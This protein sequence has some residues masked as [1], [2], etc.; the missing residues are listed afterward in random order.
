MDFAIRLEGNEPGEE[1]STFLEE[2]VDDLH[3]G[4]EYFFSVEIRF[5][6]SGTLMKTKEV[7][8][9]MPSPELA[10]WYE[11]GNGR[12][13]ECRPHSEITRGINGRYIGVSLAEDVGCYGNELKVSIQVLGG[14][15]VAIP[16]AVRPDPNL[17]ELYKAAEKARALEEAKAK[18][19]MEYEKSK[20]D[21]DRVKDSY[22]KEVKKL[23][24][25]KNLFSNAEKNAQE[26]P[27]VVAR[28]EDRRRELALLEDELCTLESDEKKEGK[29]EESEKLDDGNENKETEEFDPE[30][31]DAK[32]QEVEAAKSALLVEENTLELMGRKTDVEE[33]ITM[34]L[35]L[36]AQFGDNGDENDQEDN[37]EI[38]NAKLAV[39][40]AKEEMKK[41]IENLA[42]IVTTLSKQVEEKTAFY[43]NMEEQYNVAQEAAAK[44]ESSLQL[45]FTI[46]S[47]EES[48][49]RFYLIAPEST[50]YK[51]DMTQSAILAYEKECK[52][53]PRMRR[54]RLTAT[55]TWSTTSGDEGSK[56]FKVF[57]HAQ[58]LNG[59]ILLP[60]PE[61]SGVGL[62]DMLQCARGKFVKRGIVQ[63][64]RLR[65][66]VVSEARLEMLQAR[67]VR[68]V[69]KN[70][71]AKLKEK[72]LKK[73]KNSGKKASTK[74]H[75]SAMKLQSLAR[76]KQTRQ[77][78]FH[79]RRR[80][81]A[82][83]FDDRIYPENKSDAAIKIQALQRSI[84]A[85]K[86]VKKLRR[87]EEHYEKLRAA[88]EAS[89]KRA[90]H[91]RK[92]LAGMMADK[93]ESGED[94]ESHH[95]DIN[96]KF[97]AD[98]ALDHLGVRRKKKHSGDGDEISPGVVICLWEGCVAAIA[99]T[100]Q[101]ADIAKELRDG[102]S[103]KNKD[104]EEEDNQKEEKNHVEKELGIAGFLKE[105]T[106][107]A[108]FDRRQKAE[109]LELI[110]ALL[111]MPLEE[112][113]E[114]ISFLSAEGDDFSTKRGRTTTNGGA[115]SP[116]LSITNGSRAGTRNGWSS[117]NPN[118]A[119]SRR[120]RITSSRALSRRSRIAS[121]HR[122]V[123]RR[124]RAL[125]SRALSSR[126]LSRRAA[127]SRSISRA[128]SSRATSDLDVALRRA[129]RKWN[130]FVNDGYGI[131]IDL[132]NDSKNDEGGEWNQK[133][134]CLLAGAEL[135]QLTEYI[136][137]SFLPGGVELGPG[138]R[139]ELA[140][141]LL[142]LCTQ[143]EK[144]AL[145]FVAW[146]E[147]LE[148]IV[149]DVIEFRKKAG[150]NGGNEDNLDDFFT[151]V[152]EAE[153]EDLGNLLEKFKF[154]DE[155][156]GEIK[157]N[158]A[159][160]NMQ[161]TKRFLRKHGGKNALQAIGWETRT[162]SRG[163]SRPATNREKQDFIDHLVLE[164]G[165]G[166]TTMMTPVPD[167]GMNDYVDSSWGPVKAAKCSTLR[168]RYSHRA[169]LKGTLKRLNKPVP[170]AMLNDPKYKTEFTPP[171]LMEMEDRSLP[172][173]G[174][175]PT[176]RFKNRIG[177]GKKKNR[178]GRS[179]SNRSEMSID[180]KVSNIS[181]RR[182]RPPSKVPKRFGIQAKW[183]I[184]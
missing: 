28:L 44:D 154:D 87:T 58:L 143:S 47:E 131:F 144:K 126:A 163:E 97:D 139:L 36:I 56:D 52:M 1:G 95:V 150:V 76:G 54:Q 41:E 72:L 178:R 108:R 67:V 17:P 64:K 96:A 138:M 77:R 8:V 83:E 19:K 124:S 118:R 129:R 24:V 153:T 151:T 27:N 55:V 125:S 140:K 179:V 81:E 62:I 23:E 132:D 9:A 100:T 164:I 155:R 168:A 13:Y 82:G 120:S 94:E 136:W 85:R 130:E 181:P 57:K 92:K 89:A 141:T 34:L 172:G 32:R 177:R 45:N 7:R 10:F 84:V 37:E 29:E 137:Q 112:M 75:R 91:H 50:E 59:P 145:S 38:K 15:G 6:N 182:L 86:Y 60:S 127:T 48:S 119:A 104:K 105:F 103:K 31:L 115:S 114:E 66:A 102:M 169:G 46:S 16:F 180:E 99:I 80:V 117:P 152:S 98:A 135:Q 111:L 183:D 159:G 63:N 156:C 101:E 162:R 174:V 53:H 122:A 51:S 49:K 5:R 161:N 2:L 35:Q 70:S 165:N 68:Q 88:K 176:K 123:S 134:Q 25:L 110:D 30:L 184:A 20:V 12:Q 18:K 175:N 166:R 167:D 146:S 149:N 158:T 147:W 171:E 109:I 43:R 90:E 157:L 39:E 148:N 173:W 65:D 113:A 3:A 26:R 4:V 170:E 107:L 128:R 78:E 106:V 14:D 11:G 79:K 71:K 42:F 133:Q 40:K 69:V 93:G 121:S 160:M 21:L 33:A 74:E 22:E 116:T 142:S 73:K 61:A